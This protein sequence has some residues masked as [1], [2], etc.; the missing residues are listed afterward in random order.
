MEF[1]SGFKGL[2]SNVLD[3]GDFFWEVKQLEPKTEDLFVPI[4]T[5]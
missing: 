5:V 4:C 1:N 2:T 3:N